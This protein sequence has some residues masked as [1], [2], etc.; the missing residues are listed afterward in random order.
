MR[1]L[2]GETFCLSQYGSGYHTCPS[3][4]PEHSLRTTA[5]TIL[6]LRDTMPAEGELHVDEWV[7]DEE[8]REALTCS[9]C[10]DLL[11]HPVRLSTCSHTFCLH[12]IRAHASQPHPNCPQ[13]VRPLP[14]NI[15]SL[16]S[17]D[18]CIDAASEKQLQ[19]LEVTCPYCHH[20]T[21]VL[22]VDRTSLV[23]HRNE[24][25][26]YPLICGVSCGQS[27]ARSKLAAHER[28]ECPQREEECERCNERLPIESMA[29]HHVNER[30][31]ENCHVCALG[32][33]QL[34]LD[35]CVADH[36]NHH[37]QNRSVQCPTCGLSLEQRQLEAHLHTNFVDHFAKL[38]SDNLS[39]RVQLAAM[40]DEM[41]SLRRQ[42]ST[43][44]FFPSLA[45]DVRAA[46]EWLDSDASSTPESM[47][48]VVALMRTYR[49]LSDVQL[50]GYKRLLARANAGDAAEIQHIADE[51][52][53]EC[54]ISAM[55][56]HEAVVSVQEA[57]CGVLW[58]LADG[59]AV[60]MRISTSG[61]VGCIV[62][63]MKRHT[64]E[65]A[66][67]EH[68]CAA[69][70]RL[71]RHPAVRNPLGS[72]GA[73]E[74]IVSAMRTHTL[75]VRIRETGFQA[76]CSL[77]YEAEQS[78]RLVSTGGVDCIVAVL[79]QHMSV[80]PLPEREFAVLSHLGG[81]LTLT[82]GLAQA[83]GID[84]TV[85]AM[86]QQLSVASVQQ[87]GCSILRNC[88]AAVFNAGG[89][90]IIGGIVA[91]MKHHLSVASIQEQGCDILYSLA[92][93]SPLRERVA[94]SGAIECVVAAMNQHPTLA[95]LQD[96]GILVLCR[97][98]EYKG[99]CM[100]IAAA[101]GRQAIAAAMKRYPSNLLLQSNGNCAL[102]RIK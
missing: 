53:I 56:L 101:G 87:S 25:G 74:C 60:C 58:R 67:Q 49:D 84:C 97:L 26:D 14:S 91:A 59:P 11:Y 50:A 83:G 57:G 82:K 16:L 27:I 90:G 15:G 92:R 71:A 17:S 37:C 62:S 78:Q 98:S 13:C 35:R 100:R 1:L 68:G 69:L 36:R 24:C 33:G 102:A 18:E 31:C 72:A 88:L 70:S 93:L 8:V 30:E 20:W 4:T 65:V 51:G 54:V 40:A 38:A 34:V 32:C 94:A 77:A 44:L 41:A 43:S 76:L 12:C 7:A 28:D 86:G 81:Q 42:L 23:T 22:G 46:V 64:S 89:G 63:A 95:S 80:A 96:H 85:L 79:R 45:S 6:T 29:R 5:S 52:G 21:G 66:V 3:P 47:K 2:A 99:N 10:L 61:G 48:T 55:K 9:V 39:F 19:Q 73:I 75:V